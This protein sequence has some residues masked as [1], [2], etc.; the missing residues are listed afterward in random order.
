MGTAFKE[1]PH[2]RIGHG[3]GENVA[4]P[5]FLS[6]SCASAWRSVVGHYLAGQV[7]FQRA[8][9]CIVDVF[10]GSCGPVVHRK[11]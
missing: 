8:M 10:S 3:C 1:H 9:L 6:G 2:I 7:T 5:P 11:S 4:I